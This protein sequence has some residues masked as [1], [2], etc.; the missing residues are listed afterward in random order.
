LILPEVN[1]L[2]G[3]DAK[4]GRSHKDNF[5][6]TVKVVDNISKHTDSLWLRWAALLHDVGKPATKK[7][8]KKAGWTFHGH[9]FVGA[10]MIP[11]I[12]RRMKM[13]LN[14]KM[15]YVQKLVRLHLRPISLVDSEVTDS[16]VRRLLFEAG[17]DI[18]DLMTLCEAD[19]TSAYEDKV[20]RFL[21]NFSHVRERLKIIEEKD[22]IRH[23]QPPINGKLIIDT[24]GL[25]PC[26]EIG[27]IKNAVKD[28][29]LDGKIGNNY[30]EAYAFMLEKGKELGLEPNNK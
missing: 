12:F 22:A 7:F 6:H 19:I 26:R 18:D 20:K 9:D 8:D 15:K 16:A 23:F 13:P 25:P 4:Q 24:F 30:N 14:E 5:L 2:K 10:K 17:D 29:I 11:D 3:V 21:T 27:T 28:A 1:D